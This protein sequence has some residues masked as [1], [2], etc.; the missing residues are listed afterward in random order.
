MKPFIGSNM[1][2]GIA[3]ATIVAIPFGLL[4]W[5]SDS[6]AAAAPVTT[7]AITISCKSDGTLAL[8]PITQG[9]T[10]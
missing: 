6:K 4:F 9:A 10:K 2:Y 5:I 8:Q 1:Y 7:S 3:A